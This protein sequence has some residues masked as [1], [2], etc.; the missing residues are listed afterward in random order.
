MSKRA[1]ELKFIDGDRVFLNDDIEE[2]QRGEVTD[3]MVESY[4]VLFDDGEHAEISVTD[5][6]LIAEKE[7]PAQS[8]T[9]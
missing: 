1:S 9:P 3:L 4:V 6:A 7:A 5:Q 2:E 8:E